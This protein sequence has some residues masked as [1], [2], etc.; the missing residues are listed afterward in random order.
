MLWC[1][2]QCVTFTVV[3]STREEVIQSTLWTLTLR[4]LRTL[5]TLA[6]IT[7]RTSWTSSFCNDS[8]G[9]YVQDDSKTVI[10]S[11]NQFKKSNFKS[12]CSKH[13]Y[14]V[15]LI[16]DQSGQLFANY[17][18]GQGWFWRRVLVQHL[19]YLNHS[20]SVNYLISNQS[21]YNIVTIIIINWVF[22]LIILNQ[23]INS[24]KP[25]WALSDFF[26][27]RVSQV[28]YSEQISENKFELT[29]LFHTDVIS[30]AS[31]NSNYF[32]RF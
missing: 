8:H 23:N 12:L 4:T 6:W 14:T 5:R 20:V 1:V 28:F 19:C 17:R 27:S 24:S 7:L 30:V 26:N 11:L 2:C 29:H 16:F 13:F 9:H 25:I 22:F 31:W 32:C 10:W 3:T 21:K 18:Q 15:H